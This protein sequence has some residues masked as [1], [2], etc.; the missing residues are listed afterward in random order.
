MTGARADRMAAAAEQ[1]VADACSDGR[2][3][4][5]VAGITTA[6]DTV[7]LGAAGRRAADGDTPM[8][9]DTVVAA[10]STTKALTATVAL[11][12]VEDGELDL[13]APA[14]GYQPR[15][16]DLGVIGGF[17]DA[18]EPMLREPAR[19]VTMRHLL[20]HTAGFGYDFFDDT[21]AP[22]GSTAATSTG[23]DWS[24]RAPL[25]DGSVT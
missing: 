5:V 7:Y 8:T 24:S 4:G 18:G 1:A 3:P 13:D 19:P 10:F 16:A 21:Y 25:V 15:L 22:V 9:T 17:D 11:R 6:S 23:P 20:T 2:V 12:L 14:A